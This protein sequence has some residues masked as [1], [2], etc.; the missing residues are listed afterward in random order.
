MREPK[1]R[2]VVDHWK[3]DEAPLRPKDPKRVWKGV[4]MFFQNETAYKQTRANLGLE[5]D[6]PSDVRS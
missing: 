4:T 5:A 3:G 1:G 2:I 6:E